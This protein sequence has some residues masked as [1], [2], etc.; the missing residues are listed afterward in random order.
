[1]R[2]DESGDDEDN[3]IGGL[4]AFTDGAYAKDTIE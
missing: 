1:M 4:Q 3:L 2:A